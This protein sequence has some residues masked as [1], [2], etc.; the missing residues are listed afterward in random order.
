MR[1][2]FFTAMVFCPCFAVSQARADEAA[3][4]S[5][6]A[7][8]LLQAEVP[9]Y[10]QTDVRT[11]FPGQ[12]ENIFTEDAIYVSLGSGWK[13]IAQNRAE[14]IA[15]IKAQQ[16]AEPPHDCMR[17]GHDEVNGI[18]TTRYRYLFGSSQIT[19]DAQLWIGAD[20]LP[21]RWKAGV[22]TST[23]NY[24]GVVAPDM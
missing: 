6:V 16:S 20:G 7:A 11:D 12:I 17:E 24:E 18:P 8:F 14:R 4:Q 19:L 15:R 13:R 3:C 2:L 23:A 1:S 10:L 22:I 21:Y 5:I 9:I